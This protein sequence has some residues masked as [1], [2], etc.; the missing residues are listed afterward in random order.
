VES[1]ELFLAAA[2]GIPTALIPTG[3]GTD[4][5]RMMFP[6]NEVFTLEKI[7]TK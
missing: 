4:L 2:S 3:L 7:K 5:Y 1:H 6:N